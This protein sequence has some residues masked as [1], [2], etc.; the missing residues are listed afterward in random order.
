MSHRNAIFREKLPWK[1]AR[2]IA[3]FASGAAVGTQ[4]DSSNRMVN[5]QIGPPRPRP[6][7]AEREPPSPLE[8]Q[9]IRSPDA[10]Q[11]RSLDAHSAKGS[12]PGLCSEVAPMYDAA[13]KILGSPPNALPC[14]NA[15]P[16]K[17]LDLT[18]EERETILRALAF[19]GDMPSTLAAKL[20]QQLAEGKGALCLTAMMNTRGW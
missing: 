3:A 5:L 16:I 17:P 1:M 15:G 6:T 18:P 20:R 4:L 12:P 7:V 14:G 2:Y 10:G 9:T 19:E 11:I 13:V 8:G